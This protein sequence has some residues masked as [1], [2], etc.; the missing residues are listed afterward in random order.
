MP[1]AILLEDERGE[2]IDQIA[3]TEGGVSRLVIRRTVSPLLG[4]IDPYGDTVF[5]RLQVG[6]LLGEWVEIESL[7]ATDFERQLCGAARR[8][9]ERAAREVH[10]YVRFVGD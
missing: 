7:A 5:N 2:V 10:L 1:F 4:S 3:D 8:L 6:R 9:F